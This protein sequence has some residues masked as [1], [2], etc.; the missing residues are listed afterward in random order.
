MEEFTKWWTATRPGLEC[1]L[2]SDNLRTHTNTEIVDKAKSNGIHMHNIMPGSSHWFQ[3]HDQKPF[4][5]LKKKLKKKK[6]NFLPLISVPRSLPRDLL[7]CIFYQAEMEAFEPDI[8][9]KTFAEVG[10]W[11]WNPDQI[12]KLCKEHCS[13]LSNLK[14][15]PLTKKL[16]RTID[17]VRKEKQD[18]SHQILSRKRR[19]RIEI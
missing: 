14:Q 2:I 10:L 13:S 17:K 7:T 19:A 5:S 9:R 11:P 15:D 18:T 6:F 12:L 3:V 16:M 1:F 4:G 8:V